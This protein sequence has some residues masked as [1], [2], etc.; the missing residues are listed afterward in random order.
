[1][2][3]GGGGTFTIS[4]HSKKC[5]REVREEEWEREEATDGHGGVV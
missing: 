2:T 1:M 4:Q 3:A 5:E